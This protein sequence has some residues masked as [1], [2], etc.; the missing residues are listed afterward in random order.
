MKADPVTIWPVATPAGASV[1]S[2]RSAQDS[3]FDMSD[4]L[5]GLASGVLCA[6]D[7]ARPEVGARNLGSSPDGA[8]WGGGKGRV[9]TAG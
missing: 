6:Q 7:C 8:A 4:S 9:G 2:D 3:G 1:L 5:G